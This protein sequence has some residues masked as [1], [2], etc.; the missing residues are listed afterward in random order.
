MSKDKRKTTDD[1]SKLRQSAE[2]KL[3]ASFGE[4]DSLVD[5]SQ[6]EMKSL[7]HELRVHQIELE[8]QNDELS[9]IQDDLEITRDRY[10]HLYDFSPV[11]YL[12]LN[13][14]GMIIEANLSCSTMLGIERSSLIGKFFSRFLAKEDQ[15]AF[16]FHRK[17][18][19]ESEAKQICE[20]RL[21]RQDLTQFHAQLGTIIVK[22]HNSDNMQMQ[23]TITDINELKLAEE[24]LQKAFEKLEQ[25]VKERTAQ[26]ADRNKELTQE[27]KERRQAEAKAR[28]SEER[29]AVA[30]SG[31][32][33]GIWDWDRQSN[34]VFYSDRFREI[35]GYTFGEFPGTVDAFRSCLHPGD[36]EDVRDAVESHLKQHIPYNIEHRLKMKSGDYRWFLARGQAI[37]DDKGIATRMAGSLQDI[38][39]RKEAV[40]DL[41]D[42]LIEIQSL[43][44]LLEAEKAYLQDEIKLE[45]NNENI[46][47]QSDVLKYVLY[48]VEQ[49]AVSSTSVL[50]LGE[51]GTGKE[52][53][54][55][56]IHSLSSR[57]SRAMIKVNCAALPTNL[58]ESELFGHEKGAFTGADRKRIGRF[59]VADKATLFLDEI[60]ELPLELQSKL[61]RVIQNGEFERLGNSRT[62][63]VDVRIIAAT[64]R[65]LKEEVEKGRFRSD[66]WYRLNV[67]P[68]TVPPLRERREDIPLLVDFYI[69]K[70]SRRLG[71]QIEVIPQKTMN[72]IKNYNWPG[73][74]RELEN[75]LERAVIN[76]SS[77]K[78]HLVD[79]LEKSYRHLS[80]DLKTLE[81]VERDYIIRVLERAHWKVSG[82]NSAAQILG[83]N[84]STLRA[85]MRKLGI[86]KP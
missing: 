49:I 64:N 20:L 6:D 2:E 8:M 69:K 39:E 76:S 14:K 1:V 46:V 38:H 78:L 27:I 23:T 26:L 43:K 4:K 65:N 63:K 79:D 58:I 74:V 50:V 81:A 59:E 19:F 53:V 37:W 29:Y 9:R 7:I 16:Y 54:A 85:R 57:K 84:R 72:A 68:I 45:N 34:T 41:H 33:D 52:L 5:F 51:T 86:Q 44:K 28:K 83:L 15:D 82:K 35:L 32:T 47:G 66:L 62:T 77:P 24:A 10:V 40:Q 67:F 30:I 25:Q 48:K 80:K 56:M 22:N 55:R 73:N 11:G 21:V 60:G 12:T 75:V 61:L 31:T 13:E 3:E 70:I 17:M 42:A 18:L 36:A 71:K